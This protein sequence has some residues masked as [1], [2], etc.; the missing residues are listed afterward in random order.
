V[1]L[2]PH[3]ILNVFLDYPP[4]FKCSY[5]IIFYNKSHKPRQTMALAKVI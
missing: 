3:Q 1:V 2:F 4:K 5:I